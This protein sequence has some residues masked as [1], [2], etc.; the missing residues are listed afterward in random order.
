MTGTGVTAEVHQAA[1]TDS[2]RFYGWNIK[3]LHGGRLSKLSDRR[4]GADGSPSLCPD[5]LL[6]VQVREPGT[7]CCMRARRAGWF[8]LGE[9]PHLR[10]RSRHRRDPAV[11]RALRPSIMMFAQAQ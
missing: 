2:N 9:A 5:E 11:A 6:S 3:A 4:S 10:N 1:G 7:S 8:P